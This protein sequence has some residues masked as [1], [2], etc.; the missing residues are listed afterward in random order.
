MYFRLQLKLTEK[1]LEDIN[2]LSMQ[3][4]FDPAAPADKI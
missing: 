3:H 2:F 4:N 1:K